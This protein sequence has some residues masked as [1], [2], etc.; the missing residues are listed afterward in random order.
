MGRMGNNFDTPAHEAASQG[1][2]DCLVSLRKAGCKLGLRDRFGYT[3]A[4][5]AASGGHDDAL[6]Y[7][8]SVSRGK[9]LER[10]CG[11]SGTPLDAAR[12]GE[13]EGCV[14]IILPYV[15]STL[16]RPRSAHHT[17]IHHVGRRSRQLHTPAQEALAPTSGLSISKSSRPDS[18]IMRMRP[19]VGGS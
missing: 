16:R 7:L 12:R 2:V 15:Q 19:R 6:R 13:H 1:R 18:S 11:C 9:G 14:R 5:V 3:P 8:I 10:P 17:D 4:Y